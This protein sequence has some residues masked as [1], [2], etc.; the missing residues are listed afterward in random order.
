LAVLFVCTDLAGGPMGADEDWAHR[1]ERLRSIPY[2]A[3]SDT[4]AD[5]EGSGVTFFDKRKA[6]RGYNLYCTRFTGEAF[7]MDMSGQV[8]HSW[9]YLS[10]EE[11]GSY[12]HVM[13]LNNG[14]LLAIKQHSKLLRLDWNSR[15]V[16]ERRYAVHHDVTPAPDGSFYAIV[17]DHEIYRRMRV[18]FDAVVHLRADGEVMKKWSTFDHL[19]ELK[20]VLNTRSFLDTVLDSALAGRPERGKEVTDIKATIAKGR[21]D[22]DYFH[23]NTITVL[24][25]TPLGEKDP[26]FQEGNLLVCFRN[27]NQIAILEKGSYRVLWAWGEGEL[28]WPHH[29]TMLKDGHILVFDNGVRRRYSRVLELEPVSRTIT[30]QYQAAV[31]EDFYSHARGSAQRLPNGNTLICESDRGRAFEVTPEGEMVWLWNNPAIQSGRRLTVYRM[32]RLSNDIVTPLLR[33]WW[34]WLDRR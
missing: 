30:W 28:Q 31:P 8:V 22:F 2:V 23:L 29:P 13:M 1:L 25:A 19:D 10:R 24:P 27:V 12:H 7:L 26:R 4:V 15:S 16:W 20:N 6:Y 3:L 18:W 11:S 32:T 17:R 5:G 14:D 33:G 21:Y 9:K 34:W